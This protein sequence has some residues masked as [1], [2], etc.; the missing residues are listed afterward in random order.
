MRFV[1]RSVKTAGTEMRDGILRA[2]GGN[3]MQREPGG[4]VHWQIKND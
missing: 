4:G 1:K 3:P 2:D